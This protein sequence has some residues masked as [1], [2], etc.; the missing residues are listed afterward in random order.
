MAAD[1]TSHLAVLMNEPFTYSPPPQLASFTIDDTTGA[2]VSTNTKSR[3]RR[4][5]SPG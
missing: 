4:T 5:A 3:V 1:P 2:I